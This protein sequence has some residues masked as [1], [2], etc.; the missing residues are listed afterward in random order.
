MPATLRVGQ[1]FPA[2]VISHMSTNRHTGLKVTRWHLHLLARTISDHIT[3]DRHPCIRLCSAKRMIHTRLIRRHTRLTCR[4]RAHTG[5]TRLH[6][7]MVDTHPH[8]T[9]LLEVEVTIPEVHRRPIARVLV[10]I[11][12][13]CSNLLALARR[14]ICP[15]ACRL[16][17]RRRLST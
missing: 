5:D 15:A 1:W 13:L 16:E 7:V 9:I 8:I 10:L 3:L 2:L 6:T 17:N 11:N 12:R 14:K 4:D